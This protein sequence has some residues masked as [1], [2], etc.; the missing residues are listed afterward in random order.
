MPLFNYYDNN[1]LL[2][3]VVYESV[4]QKRLNNYNLKIWTGNA[5]ALPAAN[6][7]LGVRE[8]AVRKLS[9]YL[10]QLLILIDDK[11]ILLMETLQLQNAFHSL[12][13]W[14]FPFVFH[15]WLRKKSD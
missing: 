1:F 7:G 4:K 13:N 2:S 12:S 11:N 10:T 15:T 3:P 14:S 9:K 8:N 6:I 5:V